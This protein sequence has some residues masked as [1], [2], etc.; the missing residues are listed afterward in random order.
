MPFNLFLIIF[1]GVLNFITNGDSSP[2]EDQIKS[3]LVKIIG[4]FLSLYNKNTCFRHF[5]STIVPHYHTNIRDDGLTHAWK[6]PKK[7]QKIIENWNWDEIIPTGDEDIDVFKQYYAPLFL[8]IYCKVNTPTTIIRRRTKSYH[9]E[10]KHAKVHTLVKNNQE[11]RLLKKFML[12]NKFITNN[13]RTILLFQ[14]LYI[15]IP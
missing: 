2:D 6:I 14:F 4:P 8:C 1:N 5:L 13:T 15:T 10:H 12:T 3:H 7:A 11:G 9:N